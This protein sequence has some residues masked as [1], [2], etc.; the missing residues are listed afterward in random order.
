MKERKR[1]V[2]GTGEW[3]A[4]SD[5]IQTGCEHECLYCYARTNAAR[6]GKK[7]P[8]TWAKPV[9]NQSAVDKRRGKKNGTIMF[10]TTHDITPDNVK[11]CIIV[12]KKLVESG[13]KVL[14]VSKPHL[15]CVVDMCDALKDYKSQILFRFTIGS[16][17]DETLKKWEPGA[18]MF[19]ERVECLKYAHGYGFQTSVSCEPMLDQ[20]I[21][22]VVAYTRAYVTDAIWLGKPNKITRRLVTN[23]PNNPDA[24]QMAKELEGQFPDEFIWELYHRYEND[25]LIKWKDSIKEVVGLERSMVKGLDR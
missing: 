18:T 2:K 8:T 11:E 17:S 9:I 12:L 15:A 23:N 1:P 6:Y 13:N 16:S 4:F 14:I 3:A 24:E 7:D 19:W 21:D 25:P 20:H 5:N 22:K 10:P